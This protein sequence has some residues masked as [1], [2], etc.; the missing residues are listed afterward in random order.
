MPLRIFRQISPSFTAVV[1]VVTLSAGLARSETPYQVQWTRQFGMPYEDVS[2]SV[3]VDSLGNIYICGD[4]LGGQ[5]SGPKPVYHDAF[6]TKYDSSGNL[7]WSRQFGT[8]TTEYC[9]AVATDASGGV[10]ISG[11]TWGDLD[12]NVGA[13]S[14]DAFLTKYNDAGDRLW[15]QQLGSPSDELG[16]SVATDALGNAY[17]SGRTLGVL[18]GNTSAGNHDA[19]LAKYDPTGNNLWT[20]QFGTADW[21]TGFSVATDTSGYAYVSGFTNGDLHGNTNANPGIS[22]VF[23]AKYDPEGTRI[24]TQQIGT[25]G[26]D[27]CLSVSTDIWKHL[28]Q[29]KHQYGAGRQYLRRRVRRVSIKFDPSGNKL[30]ARQ[31]GS[32]QNDDGYSVSTDVWGNIYISGE[33]YGDFDGNTSAGESDV[34]LTKYDPDGNK[35]WTRQIGTDSWDAGRAVTTDALGNV[36]ISGETRGT[37]KWFAL[38]RRQRCVP[39]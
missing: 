19:F 29:W 23:L 34:F 24:W 38:R 3:A 36:Y 32:T 15:T 5:V 20:R 33:T 39:C 30:W 10:F 14:S 35:L 21:D 28:R 6:L 16:Y 13:G 11:S 22:D 9:Y 4:T 2:K 31:I 37:L 8:T 25:T 18:N 27:L 26:F 7:L 17:I 12:G 1:T